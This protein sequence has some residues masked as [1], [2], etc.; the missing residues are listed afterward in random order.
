VRRV[1][2]DE[3]G[4]LLREERPGAAVHEVIVGQIRPD[5]RDRQVPGAQEPPDVHEYAYTDGGGYSWSWATPQL[6]R[7]GSRLW[8]TTPVDDE[9]LCVRGETAL[10]TPEVLR[11]RR[12]TLALLRSRFSTPQPTLVDPAVVAPADP[13]HG[14]AMTEEEALLVLRSHHAG[15]T[16]TGRAWVGASLATVPVVA[17]MFSVWVGSG[18]GTAWVALGLLALGPVALASAMYAGPGRRRRLRLTRPVAE[19]FLDLVDVTTWTDAVVTVTDVD[20][21]RWS[22]QVRPESD[23]RLPEGARVWATPLRE[24]GF[25]HLVGQRASDGVPRVIEARS[26]ASIVLPPRSE[27]QD[28]LRSR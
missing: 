4:Q 21:R 9:V 12:G 22:W 10:G 19:G 26:S 17:N 23:T 28:V 24:G 6:I 1:D 8:C 18:G 27:I 13:T 15:L 2:R 25:V 7:A 5:L 20:G 3:A 16:R 14:T 11:S